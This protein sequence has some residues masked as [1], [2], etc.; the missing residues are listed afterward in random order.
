ME[1]KFLI[2]SNQNTLCYKDVF[3]LLRDGEM[4]L[5]V[6]RHSMD[7]LMNGEIVSAQACWF[8]NLPNLKYKKPFK[9]IKHYSPSDYPKFD[10][11]NAIEVSRSKDIPMDY[12]GVMGVPISFI[13]KYYP[14]QFEIITIACGNS[15]ANYPETLKELGFDPSIKYGGGLGAAVLGGKGK[16]QRLL[17]RKIT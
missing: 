1:K 13:F 14:K 9:L 2:I 11:Y 7:F 10:N 6:Q 17:I 5:G 3:P 15:W 8:T 4:W 12:T 16:Y